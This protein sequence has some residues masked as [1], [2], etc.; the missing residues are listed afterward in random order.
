MASQDE[1]DPR[2]SKISTAIRVIP[3]F[4][5]PGIMFQD[6]RT[7]LLDTRHFLILL[8]CLLRG[9]EARGFIFGPPIA[10]AIG[11]KFVPMRKPYKLPGRLYRRSILW[12]MEQT[13]LRCMLVLCKQENVL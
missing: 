10:L 8:I 11:A 2:I 4:P 12:S 9:I 6:I 1:Q 13:K 5:K 7:S 3:N